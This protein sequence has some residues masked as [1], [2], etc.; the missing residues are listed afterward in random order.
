MLLNQ[1]HAGG[2]GNAAEHQ[3][4]FAPVFR[5]RLH[6][7]GLHLRQVVE[8]KLVE[9]FRRRQ[10]GLFRLGGAL[11]VVITQPGIDNALRHRLTTG[12]TGRLVAVF[13]A[14]GEFQVFRHRQAAMET[15]GFVFHARDFTRNRGGDK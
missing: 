7:L 8:L 12:T 2:A 1:P 6:K 10:P 15:S 13:V 5:Q 3:H 11:F 9:N 4:R 14:Y